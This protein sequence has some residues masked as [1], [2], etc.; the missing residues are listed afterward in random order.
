M[1]TSR[2][3]Q[4]FPAAPRNSEGFTLLEALIALLVL[5]IG[6]LGLAALQARGLAYSHD[7]Y[8]RSQATFLAYDIVERMRARR[9]QI[10]DSTQVPA[11]MQAYTVTPTAGNFCG[12]AAEDASANNEVYCWQQRVKATGPGS[13]GLPN[14]QGTI[15]QTAGA[16]TATD[17]SDDIYQVTLQWTDRSLPLVSGQPQTSSQTWTFQP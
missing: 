3:R 17:P 12:T 2:L 15:T 10:A 5:S 8:V 1:K 11:A 4:A 16:A 6:L 7:A 14:G 13:Q 9:M